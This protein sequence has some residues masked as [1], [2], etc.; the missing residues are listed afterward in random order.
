MSFRSLRSTV[1]LG[2]IVG[3]TVVS[4]LASA[5]WYSTA[6]GLRR[7]EFD[8]T[9]ELQ[10]RTLATLLRWTDGALELEFSDELMPDFLPG[11]DPAFFEIWDHDGAVLER[12]RSLDRADLSVDLAGFGDEPRAFHLQLPNGS[13]GRAVGLRLQVHEGLPLDPTF[14]GPAPGFDSAE[15]VV[16]VAH[17]VDSL[18]T[19]LDGLFL[20]AVVVGACLVLAAAAIVFVV[21]SRA[22]RPLDRLS[23]EISAIHPAKPPTALAGG[24]LPLELEP[25]RAR[26]DELLVRIRGALERE[27][28]VAADIAHELRTPVSEL[29]SMTEVALRWP[30]DEEFRSRALEVAHT[31]A[32]RM[33][34]SVDAV[35]RLA[36]SRTS[37]SELDLQP[38]DLGDCVRAVWEGLPGSGAPGVQLEFLGSAEVRTDRA[39]LEVV[40]SNLLGNALHH[41]GRGTVRCELV[42]G[43][44][45]LRLL[46]SNELRSSSETGDSQAEDG[47]ASARTGLG[48]SIVSSFCELLGLGFSQHREAGR[49][50]ADLR[51]PRA[52]G[53][54]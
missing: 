34:S 47:V 36:R 50:V 32:M 54:G 26:L 13:P 9:L 22:L 28:R 24:D 4:A 43:P 42:T 44:V 18:A 52:P 20:R 19:A 40:L 6:A 14:G 51:F 7:E 11:L 16:V 23:A 1:I 29:R 3:V 2:T 38:I 12:S 46:I 27:R 8:L 31:V 33:T 45:L 35:L 21:L 37:R 48:L 17:G 39:S 25:I 15:A 41:G 30:D 5:A 49:W 53:G 10:A